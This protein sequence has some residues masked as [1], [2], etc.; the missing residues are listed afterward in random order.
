MSS[1]KDYPIMCA[2]HNTSLHKNCMACDAW[3]RAWNNSFD[4][5]QKQLSGESKNVPSLL[6]QLPLL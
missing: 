3:V 4:Q 1:S 5:W 6:S 2:K